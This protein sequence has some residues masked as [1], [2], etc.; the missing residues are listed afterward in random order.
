[1]QSTF[2]TFCCKTTKGQND[3]FFKNSNLYNV[4]DA[5]FS[6]IQSIQFVA[7]MRFVPMKMQF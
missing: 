5:Y 1:M 6:L 4:T 7:Y 2:T 3:D